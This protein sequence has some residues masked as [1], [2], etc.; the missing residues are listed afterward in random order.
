MNNNEKATNNK[1]IIINRM[2]SGEYLKDERNIGHEIIN[3]FSCDDCDN[4]ESNRH[5]IYLVPTGEYSASHKEYDVE[6]IILARGVSAERIEI[7]GVAIGITKIFDPKNFDKD[8]EYTPPHNKSIYS[9]YGWRGLKSDFEIMGLMQ[10]DENGKAIISGQEKLANKRCA[11]QYENKR[12]VD[13]I[14]SENIKY[15]GLYLDELFKNNK[16]EYG[17]AFYLTYKADKVKTLNKRIFLITPKDEESNFGNA[18][19]KIR[20]GISYYVLNNDAYIPIKRGRLSGS[21]M[22]TFYN[23]S[24]E[25]YYTLESLIKYYIDNGTEINTKVDPNKEY[26]DTDSFMTLIRKEHDELSYS[27]MFAYFFEKH[28]RFLEYFSKETLG[29]SKAKSTL[30]IKTEVDSS[31]KSTQKQESSNDQTDKIVYREKKNIDLLIKMKSTDGKV[32]II[33]IENKIKSGINGLKHDVNGKIVQNQL[34]KY[35][36]YVINEYKN[37]SDNGNIYDH[38]FYIFAPNYND[39]DENCFERESQKAWLPIIR[40]KDICE[41]AENYY[42]SHKNEFDHDPYFPDF[43]KAL[44]RHSGE[45]DIDYEQTMNKKMSILLHKQKS[46]NVKN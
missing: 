43:L 25:S 3:L 31:N 32:I 46:S 35:Y 1:E 10:V 5:Y 6:G 15:G 39:I 36:N 12:Q 18:D 29:I 41:A 24:E 9:P 20:N 45:K 38:H 42:N 44:K 21:S 40:Y 17:L 22:A 8:T 14:R 16:E 7:L 34:D 26:T 30:L 27:N 2:F 28:P 19:K 13:Y 37:D 11:F 23:N 4:K 33:A